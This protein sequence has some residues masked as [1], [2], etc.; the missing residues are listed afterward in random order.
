MNV[1]RVGLAALGVCLAGAAAHGQETAAERG[2]WIDAFQ[3]A[4]TYAADISLVSYCFRKDEDNAVRLPMA[5]VSD[6]NEI[7]EKARQ[8]A[9]DARRTGELIRQVLTSVHFAERDAADPELDKA[10]ADRHVVED[11]FKMAPIGWPLS[12]R[13]PFAK[14]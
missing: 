8:G 6:L 13:P 1:F 3:A 14:H 5:L 11:Y 10:C 4:K 2:F 9:Y 12:Y 7:E